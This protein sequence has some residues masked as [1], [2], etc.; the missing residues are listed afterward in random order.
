MKAAQKNQ[1]AGIV[2]AVI[3][4]LESKN[5]DR[6]DFQEVVESA[7]ISVLKKRFDSEECFYVTFNMDK[8]DIEIYREWQV[9][10][11]GEVENEHI[12]MELSIAVTHDDE[13]E[14]GDEFVEIIDFR[15]FGRRTIINLKQAL[16]HK[17]REIEKNA[18]YEEYKDRIGEIIHADVLQID[19]GRGV[20][21]NIDQTEFRMP[22]SEQ[23]RSEKYY[24]GNSIRVM[25]K[26]VKRENNRDP[27]V[28]VSR[29]DPDFIKRLFEVEVPEISEGI[30]QIRR[31]ARVPGRR[32]KIAVES[33][34]QR[35]DPV[36]SCV[37]M[38]GVRIQAIVRE[39]DKEKIDIINFSSDTEAFIKKA[40]SPNKPLMVR[41]SGLGKAVVVL[42]DDEYNKMVERQ[43]RRLEA[44]GDSEDSFEFKPEDDMVFKLAAEIS[45]YELELV[46]ETDH[47]ANQ[48]HEQEIEEDLKIEDVV[49]IH[50]TISSK[51]MES[52][53]V[54]AERL[55]DE[56]LHE[57]SEKTGIAME[58]LRD[59]R[60]FVAA[61]FQDFKI[62]DVVDLPRAYKDA[63]IS[64]GYTF[65]DDFLGDSNSA[66]CE[67]TGLDEV[68]LSEVMNV[69][70]D[71]DAPVFESSEE[72]EETVEEVKAE[73]SLDSDVAEVE[74]ADTTDED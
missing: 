63:L 8:G 49:G 67:K 16:M 68:D 18:V 38:K 31:I 29:A 34:D 66:A 62:A 4:L 32:T 20:I 26:D 41:M 46:S 19:R 33:S 74:A 39:L 44:R 51:L 12:E 6:R 73:E 11:D 45:G 72:P 53:I 42:T 22:L 13:V 15:K 24:R 10:A 21:L 9:V 43:K 23:I 60:R 57:I 35:I 54:L 52:G 36:G 27:E 56:P 50:E 71:F 47:L 69:L 64:G 28:I 37:G 40:M 2:D 17:I 30:I 59:A 61:Y 25:I 55:L 3:D 7:F 65:V 48:L 14:V 1:G 70:G 58:K 5:I